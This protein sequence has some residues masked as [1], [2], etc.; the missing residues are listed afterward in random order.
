MAGQ[1]VTMTLVMGVSGVSGDAEDDEFSEVGELGGDM[2]TTSRIPEV[3][4]W[5]TH[6]LQNQCKPEDGCSRRIE[7][8]VGY[9][10][11]HRWQN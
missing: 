10:P 6:L 7:A 5:A 11:S 9:R 8:M 1:G 3:L 2:V 4:A